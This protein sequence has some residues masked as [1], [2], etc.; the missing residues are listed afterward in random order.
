MMRKQYGISFMK[1][2]QKKKKKWGIHI[3]QQSSSELTTTGT[4][5]DMLRR[6]IIIHNRSFI[7]WMYGNN[8]KLLILIGFSHN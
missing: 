4:E 7:Y 1:Q 2:K 5:I 3:I 8:A 6:F